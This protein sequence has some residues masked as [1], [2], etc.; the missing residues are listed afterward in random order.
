MAMTAHPTS[1]SPPAGR[2]ERVWVDVMGRRVPVWVTPEHAAAMRRRAA[3]WRA[4]KAA[5]T[6]RADA[7]IAA[8]VAGTGA[9]EPAVRAVTER[10]HYCN[11]HE[12]ILVLLVRL[13]SAPPAIFWPVFAKCWSMCDAT[14]WVRDALLLTLRRQAPGPALTDDAIPER[15]RVFRGCSHERVLGV[16]WSTARTVAEGFARGHRGIPVPDP[17]VASGTI[18]KRDVFFATDDR[19]EREVVLDPDGLRDL[20]VCALLSKE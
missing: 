4:H 15:V 8:Y 2:T 9:L 18:D 1:D 6:R 11:S 12:R 19:S 13:A 14:W 5:A 3:R 20:E 16:S 7:A 10:A 17:V